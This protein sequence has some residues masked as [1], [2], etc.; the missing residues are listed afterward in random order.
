MRAHL[1]QTLYT[2][3]F[4]TAANDEKNFVARL[5]G[6]G[7]PSEIGLSQTS[8]PRIQIEEDIV[9]IEGGEEQS[10]EIVEGGDTQHL[11]E[12]EREWHRLMEDAVNTEYP[13]ADRRFFEA[14]IQPKSQEEEAAVSAKYAAIESV[15]DRAFQILLDLGLVEET[16]P[17]DIDMFNSTGPRFG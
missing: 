2:S 16:K 3:M 14:R 7:S 17:I 10:A 1:L 8:S 5:E 11:T 4:Q 15:E 6:P 13:L 9:V 12:V